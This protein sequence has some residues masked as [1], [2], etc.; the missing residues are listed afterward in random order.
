MADRPTVYVVNDNPGHD[1]TGA[2]RF[3]SVSY[4]T[5]GRIAVFNT[6]RLLADLVEGLAGFRQERDYLLLSGHVI[7]NTLAGMILAWR[8]QGINL[9]FQDA[10]TRL[11]Q[12][13]YINLLPPK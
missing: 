3:G 13:R 4:L 6:D 11:Y 10:K 5:K 9:L 12:A 1:Y 2:R 7:V 8:F